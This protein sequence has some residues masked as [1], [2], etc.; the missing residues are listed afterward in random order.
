MS[1]VPRPTLTARWRWSTALVTALLLTAALLTTAAPPAQAAEGTDTLS[2]GQ[3]LTVGQSLV[4]TSGGYR[5]VVQG[6]GN[7]V[8]YGPRGAA[9]SSGTRGDAGVLAM[10]GDGNLVVYTASTARWSTGTFGADARLVM[11]GDGNLVVY[12]GSR[13]AWSSFTGLI[14]V[15]PAGPAELRAGG[16]LRTGQQLVSPDARFVAVVQG[17]GNFV[18][19]GPGG[20]ALF[21]SHTGG[22]AD[23]RLVV[24]TDGNVVLYGTAGARWSTSTSGA[25]ARLSLQNDGNLVV[26]VGGRAAWSRVTGLISVVPPPVTRSVLAAGETLSAGQQ[27]TNGRQVAALQTDG[28]FVLYDGGRAVF[29]SGTGGTGN[30]R[31]AMQ[32][33]GNLVLYGANGARWQTGTRGAN[34]QLA[35]Q[36]D[37]N[38]VIYASGRATWS[39]RTGSIPAASFPGT[40][41]FAVGRDVAAGTYRTRTGAPQ[42]TWARLRTDFEDGTAEDILSF[43]IT[44]LPTVTTI[45]PTDPFFGTDGCATWTADL[46]PI[47]ASPTAPFGDGTWIVGSDIAAGTWESSDPGDCTWGRLSNFS[48]DA[49]SLIEFHPSL[50]EGK[51]VIQPSDAGFYADGCG[52]W[53]KVG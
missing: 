9:W 42:C 11:Q 19:Y 7:V 3:T 26:Y 43:A 23:P 13:A 50:P 27:L 24:Q 33:D 29:A 51:V 1:T 49:G 36:D 31:L 44:D 32:S 35:L 41:I 22:T 17:D 18:V 38:L 15:R 52:T 47:T 30:A 48:S 28:N 39:S 8:V 20:Q 21:A 10:Q 16:E 40:G 12:V 53:T 2:A 4:A 6:D 46:S 37:G 25:D 14:P 45:K 5:A 34:A